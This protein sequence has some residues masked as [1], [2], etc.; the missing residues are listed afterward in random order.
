MWEIST[1]TF[2]PSTSR[3]WMKKSTP[4]VVGSLWSNTFEW[5]LLIRLDF[6]TELSPST[7][8]LKTVKS[9][10]AM[11]VYIYQNPVSCGCQKKKWRTTDGQQSVPNV[12]SLALFEP[13]WLDFIPKEFMIVLETCCVGIVVVYGSNQTERWEPANTCSLPSL[14]RSRYY[15]FA[16]TCVKRSSGN[17]WEAGCIGRFKCV[18]RTAFVSTIFDLTRLHIFPYGQSN[19]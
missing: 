8:T 9:T 5:N 14:N 17:E 19:Y 1:L 11:F 13:G 7:R 6:P 16:T 15:V 2:F 18:I 12:N 4:I 10:S 3:S